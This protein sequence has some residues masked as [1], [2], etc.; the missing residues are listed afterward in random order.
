MRSILAVVFLLVLNACSAT[1]PP[2]VDVRGSSPIIVN[3]TPDPTLPP[4]STV[5]VPR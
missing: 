1:I 2:P 3:P 5:I 4:G